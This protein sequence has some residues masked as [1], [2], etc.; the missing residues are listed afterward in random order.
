MSHIDPTLDTDFLL[1]IASGRSASEDITG[2][3]LNC[4]EIGK[5]RHD[6]SFTEC[7]E[8]ASRFE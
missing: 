8:K 7:I 6:Q 5:K 4:R 2:L 3:L 1:N